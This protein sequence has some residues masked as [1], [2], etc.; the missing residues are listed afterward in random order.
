MGRISKCLLIVLA[1]CLLLSS[2]GCTGKP[3]QTPEIPNVTTPETPPPDDAADE[4]VEEPAEAPE[5]EPEIT[6]LV[7]IAE[8]VAKRLDTGVLITLDGTDII[9]KTTETG[10]KLSSSIHSSETLTV[11]S[12]VPF[13]AL[14]IK[15]DDLPG[16]FSL[17]WDGGSM[18]C[19]AE[20]F[21]HDYIRLPRSVNS[22]S[23]VFEDDST[24]SIKEIGVYTYGT[25]PYGVQDWLL[26]CETANILVFPTH[27]DDD[28]LF[29]GSVISY[30]AIEKGLTVQ[31]AFMTAHYSEPYRDHERLDGLWEMGVRHYP[32]LGTEPDYYA[33]TLYEAASYHG[34]DPIYEWQVELIRRFKPLV[35]LGHDLNGEYGH[36]QHRLNAHCLVDA[37]DMAADAEQYPE[38]AEQYGIWDTPKLYL[39]L[40][41]ENSIVFD[42]NVVLNNDPEGRT[43]FEIAQ[44]AYKC[45][46]SQQQYYFAVTQDPD[47]VLNC[48]E[49]GLY[50]T[51]VG[52]D[53][54]ADLMEH[55]ARG[56]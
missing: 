21:L 24:Q 23:F 11:E 45:H 31:T 47:S 15:W 32:I 16:V 7:K 42:V 33:S 10:Y 54:G 6:P 20:D 49:Y 2:A 39:H 56:E 51:L 3:E 5:P 48:I 18:N 25:A 40:Y 37:V 55:T 35:I 9:S 17:E 30:Y 53:T 27:A 1:M 28:T 22:V 34:Y 41:E 19:G 12:E 44:D 13:A 36:G 46:V 26:P 52:Y 8:P 43:P 38:S 50:R 14:Y 4:K 29:F